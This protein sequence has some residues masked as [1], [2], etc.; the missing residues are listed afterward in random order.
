V[1]DGILI[2]EP[3]SRPG[4]VE[5]DVNNA[6]LYRSRVETVLDPEGPRYMPH[7]ATCPDAPEFR[8]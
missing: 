5:G 3:A 2:I 1:P 4:D 7:H 8:K 6:H